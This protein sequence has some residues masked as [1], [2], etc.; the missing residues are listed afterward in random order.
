MGNGIGGSEEWGGGLEKLGAVHLLFDHQQQCALICA[1]L[2]SVEVDCT[3]VGRAAA[4]PDHRGR[5]Q[6]QCWSAAVGVSSKGLAQKEHDTC[7]R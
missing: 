3:T 4:W 6:L 7:T 1:S 2:G 5:G